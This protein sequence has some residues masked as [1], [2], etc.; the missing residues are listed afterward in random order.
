MF[1]FA[2]QKRWFLRKLH[3]NVEVKIDIISYYLSYWNVLHQLSL[4]SADE[5]LMA[6]EHYYREQCETEMTKE[7]FTRVGDTGNTEYKIASQ[8]LNLPLRA[9]P[10]LCT[11]SF[12]RNL[13]PTKQKMKIN[14]KDTIPKI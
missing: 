3:L 1:M 12:Y 6:T 4:H 7:K 2:L 10:V 11:S 14:K 8:C 5:D 13:V 9:Y